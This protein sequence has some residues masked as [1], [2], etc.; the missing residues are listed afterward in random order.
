MTHPPAPLRPVSDEHRHEPAD[1]EL[2]PFAFGDSIAWHKPAHRA[3]VASVKLGAWMSAALD[4][5]QVCDE[6]K[7][8]IREWFSAGE[9]METLCQALTALTQAPRSCCAEEREIVDD[10]NGDNA[11]LKSSIAALLSFDRDGKIVPH[12]IGGHAHKLLSAAYRR[13]S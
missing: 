12:G 10:F 1:Y 8:D 9:P 4:D 11:A 3:V 13:L 6:M 7:A 2:E 5:P